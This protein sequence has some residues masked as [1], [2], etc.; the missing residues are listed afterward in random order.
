MNKQ[1]ITK[2]EML[3]EV[4]VKV[5]EVRCLFIAVAVERVSLI[6]IMDDKSRLLKFYSLRHIYH[7]KCHP[8]LFHTKDGDSNDSVNFLY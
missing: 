7:S 5:I 6:K 1:M 4:G 8:L 2:G 3:V